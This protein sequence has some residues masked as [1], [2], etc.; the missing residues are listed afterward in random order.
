IQPQPLDFAA[1]GTL[2]LEK[3]ALAIKVQ[4]DHHPR[5]KLLCLE[6]TTAGKVLPL[7]YLQQVKHFCEANRLTSHLDGARVFNAAVK[8]G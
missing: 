3:V 1:N 8:L 5:T 7:D 6:N 2:P 4:N